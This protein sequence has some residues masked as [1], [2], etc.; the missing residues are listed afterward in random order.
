MEFAE[1]VAKANADRAKTAYPHWASMVHAILLGQQRSFK[2][3]TY[4]LGSVKYQCR[5]I[6]PLEEI[7]PALDVLVGL[8]KLART[9]EA[10]KPVYT[11]LGPVAVQ[12]EAPAASE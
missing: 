5:E 11:L 3:S 8:G 12:N 2:K 7:D 1:L 9:N 4:N 6:V 10:G